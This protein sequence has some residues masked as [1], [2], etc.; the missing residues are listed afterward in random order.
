MWEPRSLITLWASV[1]CYRDSFTF[2]LSFYT[3]LCSQQFRPSWTSEEVCGSQHFIMQGRSICMSIISHT[4]FKKYMCN[5]VYNVQTVM[6]ESCSWCVA[7]CRSQ[8]L[9]H[10]YN[11]QNKI[12]SSNLLYFLCIIIH[13]ILFL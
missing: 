2:F 5:W 12:K 4:G 11:P 8:N 9:Q 1:A 7:K 10:I 6:K 3:R 13:H